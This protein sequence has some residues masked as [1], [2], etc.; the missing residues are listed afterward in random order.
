MS[1]VR[2]AT[3]CTALHCRKEDIRT[4]RT[5]RN[6]TRTE[7]EEGWYLV[8]IIPYRTRDYGDCRLRAQMIFSTVCYT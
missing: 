2:A 8:M 5:S 4:S 6:K 7:V 1:S 3:D